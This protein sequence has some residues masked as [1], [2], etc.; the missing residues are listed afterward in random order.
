MSRIQKLVGPNDEVVAS[1]GVSGAFA[2]RES[3]YAIMANAKT[4]G[5]P[6]AQGLVRD[7]SV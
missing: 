3:F 1:Q 4:T 6:W 7:R 2:D 5:G